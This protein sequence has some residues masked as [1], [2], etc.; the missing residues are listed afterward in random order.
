[1]DQRVSTAERM[2]GLLEGLLRIQ[3][4]SLESTLAHA[5]DLVAA[6]TGADKI[7]AFL[8]DPARDSLV[9]LGTSNQPLSALQ[10]KLGL[11]VLQ[12]SNGG[13]TVAVYKT[14]NTYFCNRVGEDT[15]EL[16]GIKE[17]LGVRSEIG[18]PLEI[19]GERRG[20]LMAASQTPDFFTEDDVRMAQTVGKWVGVVAHNAQLAEAM[21][22]NA[23][24][25]GRRAG[26]EELVTTLAH[27]LRNYLAPISGRLYLLRN[28]GREEDKEDLDVIARWI[29]RLESLVHDILDVTRIDR[30][31]LL[32]A[33]QPLDVRQ[34]AKDVAALFSGPKHPVRATVEHGE[35]IL[36]EADPGRLRQC[37]ENLVANAVH[38][39][40]EGAAVSMVVAKEVQANGVAWAVIDVIDQG[41]G[42]PREVL[43]HIFDRFY[44]EG[45]R[46][47]DAG[48][49][50]GLYLA[51]RIAAL[52]GGD[53]TAQSDPG[54]GARFRLTLPISRIS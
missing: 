42:I 41:P 53:L 23:A 19:G 46:Q 13:Q 6:A 31:M 24:E 1:M 25:E 45:G 54:R 27:D 26:A 32:L 14:G 5:C 16:L 48:L 4:G 21:S 50:L 44:T 33:P 12:L 30:G 47:R 2:M 51:K 20:M 52:H 3:S 35:P 15:D 40:P 18:V 39:S 34:V 11:N 22:R 28:R 38:K 37:L 7:D 9:A 29:E 8:Y 17:A 36:V 49:G 10:R 43:P